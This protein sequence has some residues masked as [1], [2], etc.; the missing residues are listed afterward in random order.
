MTTHTHT[1]ADWLAFLCLGVSGWAWYSA[2]LYVLVDAELADFD[3]RPAV[4]RVLDT[5]HVDPLLNAVANVKFD[6]RE[7]ATDAWQFAR[8]SLRDVA[9]TMAA[10][11]ALLSAPPKGAA[12]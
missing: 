11:L 9:L 5:G 6:A 3:P 4:R 10:L 7:A 2:C 8:L 1:L 12:R